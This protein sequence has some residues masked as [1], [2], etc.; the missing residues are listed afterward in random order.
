MLKPQDRGVKG[1]VLLLG[2]RDEALGSECF[3][4]SWDR[5]LILASRV[6]LFLLSHLPACPKER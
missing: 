2:D 5:C 1:L 6:Y 4:F 3:C